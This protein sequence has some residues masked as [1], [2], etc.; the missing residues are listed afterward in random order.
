MCD[1]ANGWKYMANDDWT[2]GAA[3]LACIELGVPHLGELYP[4]HI[5]Y[6][7]N[8]NYKLYAYTEP[9]TATLQL[10]R[11]VNTSKVESS[12]CSATAQQLN[13]CIISGGTSIFVLTVNC[14]KHN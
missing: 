2:I 9:T 7:C 3:R 12:I 11:L 4:D 10:S 14:S 1:T 5:I 13:N 8:L 6:A